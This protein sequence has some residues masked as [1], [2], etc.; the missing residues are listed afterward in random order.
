MR[1]VQFNLT[2]CVL[3]LAIPAWGKQSSQN[4][5]TSQPV[6]DPQAVAVVQA[7][8]TALGGATAIGQA[9]S[10]TFQA[11][12]QGPHANGSVSYTISTD[13]DTGQ[14]VR[15]D[16]SMKQAPLIHSHFLPALVGA[17][18][19]KESQDAEFSIL[20]SGPSTL[21]SESVNVIVF[22]IGPQSFPAQIWYF[23]SANLPVRVD[24]RLPAE[25]GARRS[26]P[27]VVAL[28]DYQSVS[29][30]LYPFEIDS[31]VPGKPLETVTL[32]SVAPG[33]TIPPN[34]FSGQ[35]GDQR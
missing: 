34:E 11:Q 9:K 12:M 13:S 19:V 7:A 26:F 24:F 10:W 32:R 27:F 23:N 25:I 3:L 30:V 18:L 8:I 16:G 20:I 35:A 14:Y 2:V 4:A 33:A 28:S 22:A 17:I 1:S 5:S 21:G 29:G 6:S 31:F 15:A